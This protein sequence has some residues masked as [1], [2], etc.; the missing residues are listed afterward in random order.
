MPIYRRRLVLVALLLGV[1]F[2]AAQFHFCADLTL[3]SAGSHF[4]PFCST[5]GA[6][7]TPQSPNI[8]IVPVTNSL[9]I[10]AV[11][12]L[13]LTLL[14]RPISPRAPPSL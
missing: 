11:F 9:V 4:C 12:S 6:A 13:L 7:V 5:A 10:L 8:T 2:L 1:I 3:G 14:P